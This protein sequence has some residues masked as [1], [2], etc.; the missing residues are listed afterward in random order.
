MANLNQIFWNSIYSGGTGGVSDLATG[1]AVASQLPGR[2][3]GGPADVVRHLVLGA[4]LTRRFGATD[5]GKILAAQEANTADSFDSKHDT[6]MNSLSLA[7]G[8][9]VKNAGGSTADVLN[10]VNQFVAKF[11]SG[12]SWQDAGPST[13]WRLTEDGFYVPPELSIDVQYNGTTHNLPPIGLRPHL[14]WETN[15]TGPNGELT[16]DQ[17][18]W[19]IGAGFRDPFIFELGNKVVNYVT[20]P[21]SQAVNSFYY[22]YALIKG[23]GGTQSAVITLAADRDQVAQFLGGQSFDGSLA[24]AARIIDGISSGAI[25]VSGQLVSTQTD[26]RYK[27]PFDN[28]PNKIVISGDDSS[29]SVAVVSAGF[30]QHIT[31]FPA[32]GM[33]IDKAF[34]PNGG[35]IEKKTDLADQSAGTIRSPATTTRPTTSRRT[36][37]RST[38][39]RAPAPP[40]YHGVYDNETAALLNGVEIAGNLGAFFGSQLGTY[41]GGNSVVTQLAAGTVLG[42]IGKE[43]GTAL[44]MGGEL[45]A[46]T[47]RSR[48]RSARSATASASARCRRRDRGGLLAVDG[49]ARRSRCTSTGWE[50]WAFTTVG[51]SITTQLITNAY[52]V[53]T[54]A[55]CPGDGDAGHDVHR[56]RS[57]LDR[58][59]P[60]HVVAAKL[61]STL[62]SQVV[63]PHYPE[64][65][66]GQQIGGSV[67]GR[68]RAAPSCSPKSRSSVRSWARTSA[69]SSARSRARSSA[70]SPAT[71]RSRTAASCSSP[72]AASTRIRV[73]GRPWR[74]RRDLHAHRDAHRADAQRARGFRGGDDERLPGRRQPDQQRAGLQLLYTQDNHYWMIN[75]PFQGPLSTVAY[76]QGVDELSRLVNTGITTLAHRVTVAGGDPL[77]RLAWQNSTANNRVRASRSTSRSRR[78][79]ALSRRTRR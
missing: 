30:L 71:I 74:E 53:A 41:L 54:S 77:V 25:Q 2:H 67:G 12:Y 24:D 14:V 33:Q 62:V 42:A 63:V 48:T 3:Y 15:P 37:S 9:L 52:G 49:G 1:H 70:T 73:L 78:T 7:I 28:N 45:L 75:E 50:G 19:S 6:Y 47:R 65:A 10:L 59:Q 22:N 68:R 32:N 27:A 26:D 11:L 64:G 34:A 36:A 23:A 31:E 18:N 13:S 40:I 55:T 56:L 43:V 16:N 20:N 66:V 29:A 60:R 8:T 79:T 69:R 21:D 38:T 61:A 39:T 44:T 35:F 51:T 57:G 76:P 17:S 72:T 46:R 4:E 58:R 5:A